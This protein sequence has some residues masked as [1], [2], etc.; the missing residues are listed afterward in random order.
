LV[1]SDGS[2]RSR[3]DCGN[4]KTIPAHGSLV[5]PEAIVQLACDTAPLVIPHCHQTPREVPQGRRPLIHH[6]FQFD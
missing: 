5:L 4:L 2:N 3:S 6:P 1:C